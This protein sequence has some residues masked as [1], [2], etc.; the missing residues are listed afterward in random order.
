MSY[1]PKRPLQSTLLTRPSFPY[2]EE[3]P[4]H[5]LKLMSSYWEFHLQGGGGPHGL[6]LQMVV[7]KMPWGDSWYLDHEA[8]KRVIVKEMGNQERIIQETLD[9]AREN[10]LFAVLKGWRD[11]LY[12][13]HGHNDV[14]EE[15]ISMERAGTALFGINSYGVHMTLY[16]RTPDGMKIWVPRRTR[17]KQTYGGMLDNSVAGGLS[18]GE[19]PLECLIREASEEASLPEEL[20]RSSAKPCGTVSYIHIRDKRAG[21]ETGLIQP[22]C[23]YIFDMEVSPDTVLIPGDDEVEEFYLWSVDEVKRSLADGQFKPNCAVVLLDF[24]VRHGILTAANEP[25]YVEIISRIHRRL[26]FPTS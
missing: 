8:S 18:T 21:G 26:P 15:T 9:R 3:N 2:Y 25:D 17:S 5:Y 22:E 4:E 7:E 6:M 20:V 23:Q 12:P 16:I 1:S 24:F 13:I 11:E 14:E 10:N 19:T